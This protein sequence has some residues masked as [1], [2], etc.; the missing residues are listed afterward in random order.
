MGDNYLLDPKPGDVVKL[1]KGDPDA[2]NGSGFMDKYENT[3]QTVKFIDFDD[4]VIFE[5]GGDS[6]RR[7]EMSA[8]KP[9][10][11]WYWKPHRKCMILISR[12]KKKLKITFNN[13]GA[14]LV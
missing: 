2:W 5:N 9:L 10:N 3:I 13:K 12:E 7:I 1:V 6:F 11:S 8:D 4:S 14:D